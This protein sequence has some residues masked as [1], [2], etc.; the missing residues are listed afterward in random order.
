MELLSQSVGIDISK[1]T[2]TGC[3][4]KRYQDGTIELSDVS[5]FLNSKPG[6]NQLLKW[7]RKLTEKGVPVNFVMEATGIYYEQ[8]AYH[9]TNLKKQVHVVLPNKIA[10]YAKSLNVKTKTDVEDAK[11]ISR[12]GAERKLTLWSPPSSM[13]KELR[14]LT[15]LYESLQHDKTIS[16]NRLKQVKSGYKP[17]KLVVKTYEDGIEKLKKQLTKV[18]AEMTKLLK[19]DSEIWSKVENLL[20]IKGIGLKTIA[21]VLG[22]TQGFK[23]IKNQRQLVSYCGLDVVERES[24]TSIK[25]KTRI[26]KKGNSHIRAALHFPALVASRYNKRMSEVYIRIMKN[27]SSKMIGMVALQRRLLVLMYS[28]WKTNS[29]Y[30]ENYHL[31]GTSGYQDEEDSSSSSTRRVETNEDVN[32]KEKEKVDGAT[33]LQ[34]TQNE[35]L[36]EQASEALLRL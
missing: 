27:K 5:E 11:V 4:C 31:K 18:E 19:S 28:L 10:Y 25:G 14:A 12:F 26:S 8:L 32:T 20:T 17:V 35:P 9:L 15:R 13:F 3:V 29:P 21:I 1:S 36:Y 30:N 33:G 7:Q 2:F 6:Y 24:G 22:E 34:S 23:L 16:T